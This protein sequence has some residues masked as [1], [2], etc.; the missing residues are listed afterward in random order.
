M[1]SST[2]RPGQG[3]TI[4]NNFQ[5]F[6]KPKDLAFQGR[7]QEMFRSCTVFDGSSLRAVVENAAHKKE[8]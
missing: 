7:P 3:S 4:Q 2:S 1:R 8:L 6:A 5:R